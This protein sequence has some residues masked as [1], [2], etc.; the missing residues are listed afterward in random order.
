HAH[1]SDLDANGDTALHF[2]AWFG[3][4]KCVRLLIDHGA[5]VNAIS[6]AFHTTPLKWA[7]DQGH[8]DI[9]LE[10]KA[11]GAVW[12]RTA[13][14]ASAGAGDDINFERLLEQRGGKLHVDA[15]DADGETALHRACWASSLACARVLLR[16]SAD[17]D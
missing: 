6:H 11:E 8:H 15:R 7:I 9:I 2:A 10:L 3:S 17:V 1:I 16:H 12:E 13:L 5:D 14:H 4:L